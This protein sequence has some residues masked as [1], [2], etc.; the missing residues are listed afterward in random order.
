[1]TK[2]QQLLTITLILKDRTHAQILVDSKT[3]KFING[4][5]ND[6]MYEKMKEAK[7]IIKPNWP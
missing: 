3:C 2:K 6:N 5:Y 1:V 7:E 4:E